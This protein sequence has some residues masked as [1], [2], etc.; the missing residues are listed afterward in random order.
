[1]Y[2]ESR[3]G[4]IG[5][6]GPDNDIIKWT[7]RSTLLEFNGPVVAPGRPRGSPPISID[8]RQNAPTFRS[9]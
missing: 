2:F 6:R 4:A 5:I 3:A 8:N 1:L 7:A 9:N